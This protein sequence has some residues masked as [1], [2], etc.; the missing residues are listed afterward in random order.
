MSIVLLTST[1]ACSNP[2]PAAK[3]P[4]PP[5]PLVADKDDADEPMVTEARAETNAVFK[6]VLAGKTD[7]DSM[8]NRLSAK[9][10]GFDSATIERQK[11][12][13]GELK[14]ARFD[15]TLKGRKGQAS[16]SVLMVKQE[17]GK[18]AIATFEGPT[19]K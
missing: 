19:S 12:I 6:N 9:L 3:K 5:A 14:S 13:P 18:W 17:N 7:N 11:L 10:N 1:I 4:V 16:F 15:G 2:D 8:L